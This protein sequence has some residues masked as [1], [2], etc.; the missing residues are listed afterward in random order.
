MLENR[1]MVFNLMVSEGLADFAD[2]ADFAS[3]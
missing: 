2:F 3:K 1:A